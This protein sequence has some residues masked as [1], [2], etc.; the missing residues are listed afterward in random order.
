MRPPYGMRNYQHFAGG[1]GRKVAEGTRKRIFWY[2]Q[3]SRPEWSLVSLST[4]RGICEGKTE[5]RSFMD[6]GD[7]Y[8]EMVV[9][10]QESSLRCLQCSRLVIRVGC[11]GHLVK[12]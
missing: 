5:N 12:K 9:S 4:S 1:R 7:S 8:R 11:E 3:V 2:T 10:D 6:L